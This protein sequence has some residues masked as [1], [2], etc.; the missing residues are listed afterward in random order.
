[1]RNENEIKEAAKKL[2]E[3]SF[4]DGEKGVYSLWKNCEDFFI[5]GYKMATLDNEEH[6][7]YHYPNYDAAT[8]VQSKQ[9]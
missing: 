7:I 1:M 4:S 3:E 2:L 5:A 6:E 8:Y 9:S